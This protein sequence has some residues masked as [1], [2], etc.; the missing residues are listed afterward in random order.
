MTKIRDVDTLEDLRVSL[1]MQLEN[2]KQSCKS[3]DDLMF[4]KQ[5]R[6]QLNDAVDELA[7]AKNIEADQFKDK[8]LAEIRDKEQESDKYYTEYNKLLETIVPA[9]E[10]I[11]K[12]LPRVNWLAVSMQSNRST[13]ESLKGGYN[14]EYGENIE[15]SPR[16]GRGVPDYNIRNL[17][18]WLS[19]D[20]DSA[21]AR[22]AKDDA[23][24]EP[25]LAKGSMQSVIKNKAAVEVSKAEVKDAS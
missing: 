7:V 1:S 2:A 20:L 14:S 16:S 22:Q 10:G 19:D 25:E 11:A 9:L 3:H 24:V 13:I 6:T 18:E 8:R 21:K 12:L 4:M 23:S 17:L 15:V 5:L